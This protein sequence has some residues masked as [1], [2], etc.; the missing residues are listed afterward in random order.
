MM[1]SRVKKMI[2]PLKHISRKANKFLKTMLTLLKANTHLLEG[3]D[4]IAIY[5]IN[6]QVTSN[7]AEN[8]KL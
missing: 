7:D 6:H 4:C 8:Q 3:K 1:V 5:V 2:I